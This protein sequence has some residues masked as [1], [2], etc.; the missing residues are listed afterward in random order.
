MFRQSG[1]FFSWGK[2]FS[3]FFLLFSLMFC[4]VPAIGFSIPL[5]DFA[6]ICLGAHLYGE[7]EFAIPQGY[8][9]LLAQ[10]Q[11]KDGFQGVAF[12]K[13]D[14]GEVVIAFSGTDV[15]DPG[16]LLADLGIVESDIQALKKAIMILI[17]KDQPNKEDKDKAKEVLEHARVSM[18]ANPK[19]SIYA[20]IESARKFTKAV[21][22]LISEKQRF[23]SL[24]QDFGEANRERSVFFAGHSLGGFLAEI[25]AYENNLPALT[26]NAPGAAGMVKAEKSDRI[27]NCIRE[28]DL[29]GIYGAHIG[30][31]TVYPYC[32]RT[33]TNFYKPFIIRNHLMRLFLE[34]LEDGMIPLPPQAPTPVS[35]SN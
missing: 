3:R 9:L 35:L 20:Q 19:E 12:E 8:T 26:F 14:S 27:V 23:A 5:V 2:N 7:K 28:Y 6:R 13:I 1:T 10:P 15:S 21:M 18:I 24:H 34:D 31:L 16:D 32:K 29:A 33:V 11:I 17:G 30:N 25:L 4:L 22:A